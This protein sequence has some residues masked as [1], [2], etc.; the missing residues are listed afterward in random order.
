MPS[1]LNTLF[2][3]TLV[4]LIREEDPMLSLFVKAFRVRVDKVNENFRYLNQF[5]RVLHETD[6]LRHM[7]GKLIIPFTSRNVV[8]KTL[9]EAHPGQFGTNYL[10]QNRSWPHIYRQ[11]YFYGINCSQCTKTG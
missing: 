8:I 4:A 7:D 11:T 2:N 9:H 5:I 6:G 3:T 10:A 1:D